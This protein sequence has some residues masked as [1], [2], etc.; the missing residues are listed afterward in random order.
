MIRWNSS[1]TADPFAM[2]FVRASLWA[3]AYRANL[4]ARF[5]SSI[6]HTRNAP[7][8]AW[9]P[10]KRLLTPPRSGRVDAY[11][12][13]SIFSMALACSAFCSADIV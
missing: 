9:R 10:R 4:G 5:K 3:V 2:R 8:L 12:F 7:E 13:F 11:L 6:P 1:F